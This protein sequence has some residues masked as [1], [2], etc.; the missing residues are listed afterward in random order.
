MKQN[1]FNI[2]AEHVELM[3]EIMAVEGVLTPEL[4]ERL[5]I[6]EQNRDVKC[7]AYLEIIKKNEAFNMAVDEEIKRLQATKKRTDTLVKS[8]KERLVGAVNLFGD[9]TIGTV[10]FGTRKSTA[11]VIQDAAKIP[12]EYQT[13]KV[14]TTPDKKMIKEVLTDGGEIPGATLE[15]RRTLK[16]K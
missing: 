5:I 14:T 12:L 11:C 13:K 9:F 7:V 16:I 8:L 15:T 4:E 1:L 10:E 3:N 2:T 6:N